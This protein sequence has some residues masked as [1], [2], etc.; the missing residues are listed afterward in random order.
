MAASL[1]M[2]KSLFLTDS[3]LDY[4]NWHRTPK[5][6]LYVPTSSSIN[7]LFCSRLNVLCTL[8]VDIC[9][10]VKSDLLECSV[11]VR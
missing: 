1:H 7:P 4:L 11:G 6:L 5:N 2:E 9:L 8:V 10:M 3:T